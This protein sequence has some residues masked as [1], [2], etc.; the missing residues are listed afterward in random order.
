M[1][2][3]PTNCLGACHS[4]YSLQCGSVCWTKIM[5]EFKGPTMASRFVPLMGFQTSAAKSLQFNN[6]TVFTLN[7]SMAC[8]KAFHNFDY[9]SWPSLWIQKPELHFFTL[10]VVLNPRN[11]VPSCSRLHSGLMSTILGVKE[12]GF[13]NLKKPILWVRLLGLLLSIIFWGSVVRQIW[14]KLSCTLAFHSWG[15]RYIELDHLS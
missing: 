13:N 15:Q 8:L 9:S 1:L 6:L 7:I 2:M 3:S 12:F 14:F 5:E 10:M 4:G 11:I